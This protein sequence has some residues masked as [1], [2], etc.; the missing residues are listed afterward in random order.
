MRGRQEPY[1]G[2]KHLI[3]ARAAADYLGVSLRSIYRWGDRGVMPVYKVGGT[4]R[5]DLR[6]LDALVTRRHVGPDL[7]RGQ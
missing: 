6:D 1:H 5:Y 4:N 3:T 2:L 7:G